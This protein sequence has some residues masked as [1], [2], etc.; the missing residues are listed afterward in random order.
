MLAFVKGDSRALAIG[1]RFPQQ[2]CWRIFAVSFR[3]W[4]A[5]IMARGKTQSTQSQ[6]GRGRGKSSR[7]QSS[8]P[9]ASPR[10]VESQI[11]ESSPQKRS[12]R[13]SQSAADRALKEKFWWVPEE[14]IDGMGQNGVTPVDEVASELGRLSATKKY[15]SAEFWI[16]LDA[17]WSF[18]RAHDFDKVAE[19][20]GSEHVRKEL[21]EALKE[22]VNANPSL[23]GVTKYK[24]FIE[25]SNGFN[26]IE[27]YGCLQ[28]CKPQLKLSPSHA[29]EMQLTTLECILDNKYFV[30]W[31]EMWTVCYDFFE[32]LFVKYAT[33]ESA[34]GRSTFVRTNRIGVGVFMPIASVDRV[35][36]SLSEGRDPEP[37]PL[38]LCLATAL[39][40]ALYKP[41]ALKFNWMLY[42]INARNAVNNV[43][44]HNF[45]NKELQSFQEC[46]DLEV[47]RLRNNSDFSMDDKKMV[48]SFCGA[49]AMEVTI[50]DPNDQWRNLLES[51]RKTIAVS[52]GLVPR[53]PWEELLYG[54]DGKIPGVPEMC[55]IPSEQLENIKMFREG[56]LGVLR[57]DA[58]AQTVDEY[59]KV[60][61]KYHQ[62][63]SR[64]HKTW[65]LDWI[66]LTKHV[67]VLLTQ[68]IE[69]KALSFF[70]GQQEAADRSII[71]VAKQIEL[72]K[73][74]SSTLALPPS[75]ARSLNSAA[76]FL[77]KLDEGAAAP[78]TKDF[79]C[80]SVFM[81][82]IHKFS[83]NFIYG[84]ID[85][86]QG[87]KSPFHGMRHVYGTRALQWH[88]ER[89]EACKPGGD[90]RSL[91]SDG[92]KLLKCF[93]WLLD[94]QAQ[95]TVQKW[96]KESTL[97]HR[98]LLL[99]IQDKK[100]HCEEDEQVGD[101]NVSTQ[102]EFDVEKIVDPKLKAG[103]LKIQSLFKPSQRRSSSALPVKPAAKSGVGKKGPAKSKSA[104]GAASIFG[105]KAV[106]E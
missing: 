22:P 74:D 2:F 71:K 105:S 96:V 16:Q 58:K 53:F 87:S 47:V 92:L 64:S 60:L 17:K 76:V 25:Y 6:R 90:A 4:F 54:K 103:A 68:Q 42:T 67:E 98:N 33:N 44:Y 18:S 35:E 66:F 30:K 84:Y 28:A 88:F 20:R 5:S 82:K 78:E 69:E 52:L 36:G 77:C 59:I 40:S 8:S 95:G 43:I 81:K 45:E 50:D 21:D 37:E 61:K 7:Q 11:P 13:I 55:I 56:V 63:F 79:A 32:Q 29:Y 24:K 99:G 57:E 65:D 91:G 62:Q 102:E 70:P 27:L 75:V 38:R 93:R 1:S 97:F 10:K 19:P 73:H 106:V 51:E 48:V 80:M 46:M 100:E 9:A 31:P 3:L 89:A 23:R 72:L 34:C 49:S 15:M 101:P 39:G 83:E 26:Y 85:T 14:H 86:K 41:Q 12:R 104:V 94:M